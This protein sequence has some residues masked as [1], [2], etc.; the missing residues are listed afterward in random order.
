MALSAENRVQVLL[1]VLGYKKELAYYQQMM[2]DDRTR[3]DVF[4]SEYYGPSASD[5]MF[6]HI[7]FDF[8]TEVENMYRRQLLNPIL[9]HEEH[10]VFSRGA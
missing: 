9:V 8:M 7:N 2:S 3:E 6:Y 5:N 10:G 1:S 4:V